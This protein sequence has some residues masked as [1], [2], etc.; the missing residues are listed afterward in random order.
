MIRNSENEERYKEHLLG[1]FPVV[2]WKN[3]VNRYKIS[4]NF[5]R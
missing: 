3:Y 4:W 5:L 2:M 1:E